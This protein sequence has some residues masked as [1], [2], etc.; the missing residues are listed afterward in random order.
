MPADWLWQ[1]I[2]SDGTASFI[3]QE[4]W[5]IHVRKRPEIRDAFDLTVQAMSH[6]DKVEP[7][8]HRR[9]EASRYFRLLMISAENIRPGYCLRVSVKYVLQPNGAWYKFYQSCWFERIK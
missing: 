8:K 1:G 2:N 6:P 7:D 9:D 5:E 3:A 4:Q